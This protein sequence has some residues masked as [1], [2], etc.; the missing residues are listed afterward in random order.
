MINNS[1]STYRLI[2]VLFF[3]AAC[4]IA[5][6]IAGFASNSLALIA[7]AGHMLA[8]VAALIISLLALFIAKSPPNKK[9]TFGYY[10]AEILAAL[11]N[12]LILLLA[13]FYI[14]KEA[15]L[16]ILQP[17]EVNS[18]VMLPVAF[19]GLL[20]N[21]ISL[22][23]L[24]NARKNSLNM[25]MVWLHILNDTL[26][27]VGAIVSGL[28][29]YFFHIYVADS[30]TSMMIATLVLF[31]SWNL[32]SDTLNILMEHTPA[33]IDH[34]EV[35]QV[36]ENVENVEKVH[37]LHIWSITSGRDA[38]S[39]HVLIKKDR[40]PHFILKEI[41]KALNQ[42]FKIDHVTIQIEDRCESQD[43]VCL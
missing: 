42:K 32:I 21:F 17:I 6:V 2:I 31:S 38:M 4:L 41:Q 24:K 23:I 28:L 5:E 18:S 27:S 43:R 39:A 30:I 40:D 25:K 16:R 37:D 8:D 11:L 14:I 15:I 22:F 10:R 33:H 7:D 13:S 35:L 29:I 12:G 26:G 1:D 19:L 36:I 9:A 34:S 20:V 3:T